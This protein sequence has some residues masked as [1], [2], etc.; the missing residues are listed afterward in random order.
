[1]TRLEF[2]AECAKDITASVV[3]LF[4]TQGDAGKKLGSTIGF[5]R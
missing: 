3:R 1:M 5:L 2:G 4:K